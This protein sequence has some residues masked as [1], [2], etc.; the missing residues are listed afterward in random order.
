[1][2]TCCFGC[3]FL[4]VLFFFIHLVFFLSLFYRLGT[5]G[6]LAIVLAI[7]ASSSNQDMCKNEVSANLLQKLL[8]RISPGSPVYCKPLG[9]QKML[10][11]S[12]S[13]APGFC[14]NGIFY[15]LVVYFGADNIHLI[16]KFRFHRVYWLVVIGWWYYLFFASK[17]SVSKYTAKIKIPSAQKLGAFFCCPRRLQ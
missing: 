17:I 5:M 9:Q 6:G 2:P 4:S 3:F 8:H 16:D 13:Q 14:A 7:I 12:F 15:I 1:M 11:D 10:K